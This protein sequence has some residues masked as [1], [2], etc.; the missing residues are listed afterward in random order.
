MHSSYNFYILNLEKINYTDLVVT[1]NH[2]WRELSLIYIA[3]PRKPKIQDLPKFAARHLLDG[4]PLEMQDGETG[5]LHSKWLTAVFEALTN[6][7]GNTHIFVLSG[8]VEYPIASSSY[9]M[10]H[11]IWCT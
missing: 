7:I 10:N 9:N 11:I 6:L 4:F 8:L 1:V 3:C 5:I 2:I